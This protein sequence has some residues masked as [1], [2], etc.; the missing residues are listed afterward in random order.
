MYGHMYGY[1][2]SGWMVLGWLWMG[3]VWLVP[4]LLLFALVKYLFGRTKPPQDIEQKPDKTP[5]D[6]VK[7]A[8]AKGE[9]SR[10]EFLQKQQDLK[11]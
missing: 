8:Y 7:E 4:L 9:I 11:S 3:L 10:E 6:L 5:M 2:D 1:G